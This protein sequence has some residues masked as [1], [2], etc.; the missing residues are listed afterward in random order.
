MIS[1]WRTFIEQNAIEAGLIKPKGSQGQGH[2]H[3]LE[4][5]KLGECTV[6]S[7]RNIPLPP[8]YLTVEV[9]IKQLNLGEQE[10]AFR[11]FLY[12]RVRTQKSL[13][14]P[15]IGVKHKENALKLIYALSKPETVWN[16]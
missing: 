1:S 13:Y 14:A 6:Y 9:N 12:R 7:G 16:N 4:D 15:K 11:R 2:G 3:S 5:S 10:M 8:S